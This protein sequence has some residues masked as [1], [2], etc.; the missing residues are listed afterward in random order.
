MCASTI[1]SLL[2]EASSRLHSSSDSPRLDAELILAY[3]LNKDRTYLHTWPEQAPDNPLVERFWQYIEKRLDQYPVAYITGR[4]SFWSFELNVTPEVLIP[5]PETELL[6]ETALTLLKNQQQP[7]ILDLGTGSGAIALAL[8]S[9]RTDAELVATDK[10][11]AALE[12]AR[13]NAVTLELSPRIRF[14]QSDWFENIGN[15][16]FDLIVSNPPYIDPDDGHLTGSIRHEPQCA[17]VAQQ[18]GYDDL[19][20]LIKAAPHFLEKDGWLLLEH[21][22]EQAEKTRDCLTSAGFKQVN[23]GKDLAGQDRIS[24][25]Q[26]AY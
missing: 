18:H 14:I 8:A 21:G 13:Q 20:K 23:T 10:S 1:K 9:E 15:E 25:G 7:K 5:R 6:V 2:Q 4:Q 16:K 26:L 11:A 3:C 17:L 22:F 24:F 12:V 19:I